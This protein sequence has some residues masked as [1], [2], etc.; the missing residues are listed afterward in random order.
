[1]AKKETALI[2]SARIEQ[3]ILLIRGHKVI[4]DSDLAALYGVP[5]KRLNEQGRRNR[6]RFPADFMFQLTVHE[7]AVLRSQ[8]ATS[9][10]G[11]GGRR[12]RPYV[13]T[14]YGALMAATIL[15]SPVA[16]QVSIQIV[17]TFVR[18]RQLLATHAQLTRKLVELERKYD[19]QF[20][21]VFDAIRELMV[22]PEPGAKRRIGFRVK[23]EED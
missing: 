21:V 22:P 18:L 17:R 3:A 9:K 14:E 15:N 1:M 6:E 13:F 12:Y 16:V 11:R 20:K 8:F 23:G 7:T 4:L 10:P 5:T 2:P 19:D